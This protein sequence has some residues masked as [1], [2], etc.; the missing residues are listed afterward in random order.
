[1]GANNYHQ[2]PL[3]GGRTNNSMRIRDCAKQVDQGCLLTPDDFFAETQTSTPKLL[4][5]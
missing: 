2:S 4:K 3:R 1:M 5:R